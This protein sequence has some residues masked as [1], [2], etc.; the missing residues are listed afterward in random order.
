MNL[1][2]ALLGVRPGAETVFFY[3]VFRGGHVNFHV[4]QLRLDHS[5]FQWVQT[6]H[7]GA[8]NDAQ[9]AR[10]NH[11]SSIPFDSGY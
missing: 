6:S 1:T 5:E 8:M 4:F 10:Q 9:R 2:G 3:L 11:M 7:C